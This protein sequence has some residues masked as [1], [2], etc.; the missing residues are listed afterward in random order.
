MNWIATSNRIVC[1]INGHTFKP[2]VDTGCSVS[3]LTPEAAKHCNIFSQ[4]DNS[5]ERDKDERGGKVHYFG[6]INQCP[7]QIG[8]VTTFINWTICLI[9]EFHAS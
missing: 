3:L 9:P 6:V 4:L 5:I 7:V 2:L 8:G 1:K